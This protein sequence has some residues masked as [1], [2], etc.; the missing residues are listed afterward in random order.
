MCVVVAKPDERFTKLVLVGEAAQ[1]R[2]GFGF[3]HRAVERHGMLQCNGARHG[4]I[5]KTVE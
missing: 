5:D 4:L 2:Q 1:R 3:G